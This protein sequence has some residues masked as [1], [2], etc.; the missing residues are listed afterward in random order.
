MRPL[1]PCKQPNPSF[2]QLRQASALNTHIVMKGTQM[3]T[4]FVMKRRK[5]TQMHM[6]AVRS[7]PRHISSRRA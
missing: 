3:Q 6:Q 7:S 4:H 2:F 5:D 1:L